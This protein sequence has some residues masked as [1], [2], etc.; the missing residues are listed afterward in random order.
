MLEKIN[1]SNCMTIYSVV[2]VKVTKYNKAAVINSY[3]QCTLVAHLK[4]DLFLPPI[5][6][7]AK[8]LTLCELSKFEPPIHLKLTPK[9]I[10]G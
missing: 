8:R 9:N 1:F 3:L 5:H 10:G 4:D 7:L 2:I 6:Y